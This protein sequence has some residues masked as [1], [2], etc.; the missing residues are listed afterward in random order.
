MKEEWERST[1]SMSRALVTYGTIKGIQ[2]E[3]ELK[4]KERKKKRKRGRDRRRE[5]R[6]GKEREARKGYVK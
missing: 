3:L 2:M 1:D 6:R 4:R 5:E